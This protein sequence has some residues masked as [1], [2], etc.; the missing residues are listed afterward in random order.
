[1]P[2]T[3]LFYF[4][5]S[6]A[7]GNSQWENSSYINNL[8]SYNKCSYHMQTHPPPLRIPGLTRKQGTDERYH[9]DMH[10]CSPQSTDS[11]KGGQNTFFFSKGKLMCWN[12]FLKTQLHSYIQKFLPHRL[13]CVTK[14]LFTATKRKSG[15][16]K[17]IWFV[18]KPVLFFLFNNSESCS[19]W[20]KE[21]TQQVFV[22]QWHMTADESVSCLVIISSK[23]PAAMCSFPN[24]SLCL[25]RIFLRAFF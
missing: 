25:I 22:R 20:W 6:K 3:H 16:K 1:M 24:L 8:T 9:P 11:C 10:D 4:F 5:K 2:K 15:E 19:W 12:F 17:L 13:F 14:P 21:R 23:L 7:V 18:C